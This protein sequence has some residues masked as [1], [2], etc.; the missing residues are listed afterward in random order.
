MTLP[1]KNG[2]YLLKRQADWLKGTEIAGPAASGQT[3][4]PDQDYLAALVALMPLSA[5][6][7]LICGEAALAQDYRAR[8]PAARLTGFGLTGKAATDADVPAFDRFIAGDPAKLSKARL[9]ADA[10]GYDL[11]VLSGTL[12]RM[13]EPAALLRR[14]FGLI[15]PGGSLVVANRNSGH[16]RDLARLIEG[17][18]VGHDGVS[19]DELEQLLTRAGFTMMRARALRDKDRSEGADFWLPALEGLAQNAGLD[20]AKQR[21]RARTLHYL[22]VATRPEKGAL[23]APPLPVHMVELAQKMDVRTHIPARALDAEP[24]LHVTT[25]AKRIDLPDFGPRGG[26][27]VVQRPRISDPERI[28]NVVAD[29]QRRGIVL[30]IEYD[31][32]PSLV[33]RVLPREDVP[34]IYA[35]NMALAHAVQTSTEVLARQFARAN[36]EVMVMPNCAETLAPART[37][38]AGP[39]RVLFAAL[40]RTRTADMAGLLAPAIDALGDA[41]SFDVIHDRQFF[42]ALPTERKQFHPL[43]DYAD[44][45]D[46]VGQADV[47]LMPLEGLP[48]ELGKSDVKWVEAASR[49]AVAI[50]SPAVYGETIR[51]GENGFLAQ[52]PQDWPDLLISLAADPELRSRI[53]AAARA[54]VAQGRMMADQV[55][56]RRDWYLELFARRAELFEAAI[57]RSPALAERLRAG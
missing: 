12:G 54:E 51:H 41:L 18:A 17:R 14:L 39:M 23:V 9:A 55:G 33:A 37:H 31:D 2:F 8:N 42:D 56:K 48:E 4:A 25:S 52:T 21:S 44:Y 7:I 38:S 10:P 3:T 6:E 45:L 30:I 47:S 19:H 11:A 36:P 28:L 49:G 46:L 20:S 50:A 22:A 57:G 40:N 26:L 35:R 1:R 13:A 32:D 24:A 34:E 5:R 27:M 16:W 43:M 53:A 29:C 15:R